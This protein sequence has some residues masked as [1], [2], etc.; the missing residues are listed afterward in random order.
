MH[1]QRISYS[2]NSHKRE[3]QVR[4]FLIYFPPVVPFTS[5]PLDQVDKG[6]L[7]DCP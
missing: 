3:T 6:A 1:C 5:D 7:E 4:K 2:F